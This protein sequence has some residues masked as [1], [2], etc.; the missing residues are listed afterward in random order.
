MDGQV[1]GQHTRNT[2]DHGGAGVKGSGTPLQCGTV[3]QVTASLHVSHWLTNSREDM[4]PLRPS[5]SINKMNIRA[6]L[7]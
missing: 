7:I 4:G 1:K 2:T 3:T 5:H 6:I